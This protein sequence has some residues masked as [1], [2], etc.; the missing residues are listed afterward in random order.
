MKYVMSLLAFG[1]L[2]CGSD[3]VDGGDASLDA[4]A[5]DAAK[6]QGAQDAKIDAPVDS[7][8]DAIA[9]GGTDASADAI[10][11]AG[12]DVVV[13]D[14]GPPPDGGCVTANDCKLFASYC[15]TAA[16]KCI[17]LAKSEADPKCSG[18]IIQC[19]VAPCAGKTAICTDAG[20]CGVAP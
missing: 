9:E 4:T 18:Q 6:D 17:P 10:S 13:V 14:S 11:D 15:S 8:G 19:L 3:A 1:L 16:C 12:V 20:T 7:G 5:S 2:G